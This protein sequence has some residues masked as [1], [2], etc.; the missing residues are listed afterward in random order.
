MHHVYPPKWCVTIVFD[1]SW[2]DYNTD[3]VRT[4]LKSPWILGE[5]LEK[6]LNLLHSLENRT[7]SHLM[8]TKNV[9]KFQGYEGTWWRDLKVPSQPL[10]LQGWSVYYFSLLFQHIVKLWKILQVNTWT[11]ILILRAR[12]LEM[13]RR[14]EEKWHFQLRIET[15]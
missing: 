5:V 15:P 1:F 8:K 4:A 12:I 14:R 11:N 6:S 10:Q 2:D 9:G 3:T 13:G 7:W